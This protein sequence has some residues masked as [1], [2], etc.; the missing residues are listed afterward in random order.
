[1]KNLVKNSVKVLYSPIQIIKRNKGMLR[2]TEVVFELTDACNSRCKHCNIW[3]QK[4]TVNPLNPDEIYELFSDNLFKNL[5]GVI[6]TGGEIF[7]RKDLEEV[8]DK[9]HLARPSAQIWL[10][11]NALLPNKAIDLA[12]NLIKKRISFGVGISLD[13]V[14]DKHDE[15]RGVEGNFQKADYL[16]SALI[17]LKKDY[18]FELGIG[19][20]LSDKTINNYYDL[21]RY[22]QKKRVPLIVQ[23]YDEASYYSNISED[24]LKN[25][26]EMIK[27]LKSLKPTLYYRHCIDVLKGKSKEFKCFSL[28]TFFL[29]RC[30]GQISP[31]LKLAHIK[32]GN[33][34]EKT[35]KKIWENKHGRKYRKIVKDCEGCLNTWGV[36]W[37][38][39]AST[40]P[41]LIFK[42]KNFFRG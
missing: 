9:I 29:L 39:T 10:S 24:N 13:G 5:R 16:I 25:K 23:M 1:M 27:I 20:T 14:A 42:I 19:F 12:K 40:I 41:V 15:I 8:I 36:G 33:I 18:E 6:L 11:T 37:S 30:D 3:N 4:P 7:V 34:R 35:F 21:K 28:N 17:G 38:Q 31:C 22:S 2:P 32:A 26:K